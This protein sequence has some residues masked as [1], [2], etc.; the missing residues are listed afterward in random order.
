MTDP[1]V[2]APRRRGVVPYVISLTVGVPT[3]LLMVYLAFDRFLGGFTLA[4]AVLAARGCV[5]AVVGVRSRPRR[6]RGASLL[7]TLVPGMAIIAGFAL[8][9]VVLVAF[10][11]AGGSN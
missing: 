6:F 2:D 1:F 5:L 8:L 9:V 10:V 3:T 7:L 4:L 11:T